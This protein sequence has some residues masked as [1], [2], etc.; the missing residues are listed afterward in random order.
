MKFRTGARAFTIIELLVAITVIAVLLVIASSVATRAITAS[1]MTLNTKNLRSIGVTVMAYA[2]DHAGTIPPQ[3]QGTSRI[4]TISYNLSS[5]A[6]PR[7]MYTGSS[8]GV[9]GQ[10]TSDYI[11]S[12][13]MFYSP[14]VPDFGGNR[15]RF[16]QDPKGT[17]YVAYMYYYMPRVDETGRAPIVSG[18]YNDR[19]TESSSAPLYSD[20]LF[21]ASERSRFKGTRFSVIYLDG[22]IETFPYDEL[23][24]LKSNKER[25]LRLSQFTATP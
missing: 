19:L 15:E 12:P 24:A 6:A 25:V 3:T 20:I 2:S 13:A 1:K 4:T 7:K 9:A 17:F 22:H 11:S 21:S 23:V 10:G 8:W 5:G 16:P 14:F 18:L